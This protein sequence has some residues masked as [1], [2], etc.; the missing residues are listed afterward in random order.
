M[1][2]VQTA[3]QS[4]SNGGSTTLDLSGVPEVDYIKIRWRGQRYKETGSNS[5]SKNT[6]STT[7]TEFHTYNPTP[8][9]P[10]GYN[11]DYHKISSQV[12][13]VSGD[14][15]DL[16][17]KHSAESDYSI[18]EN[19]GY[20]VNTLSMLSNYY[21]TSRDSWIEIRAMCDRY[22]I[23]DYTLA[24]TIY[25]YY[26][27]YLQ[28]EDISASVGG[29]TTTGPAYL[30]NDDVSN[31]YTLNNVT[32]DA[33]NTI[34]HSVSSAEQVEYQ[35]EYSPSVPLAPATTIDSEYDKNFSDFTFTLTENESVPGPYH[36][37]IT[38]EGTTYDTMTSVTDWYYWDGAAWQA[39][40]SAGV[41]PD[42]KVKYEYTN[43]WDFGDYDWSARG[44]AEI[45]SVWTAGDLAEFVLTIRRLSAPTIVSPGR[46][47]RYEGRQPHFV[48]EV[49][50]EEY[51][52]APKHQARLKLSQYLDMDPLLFEFESETA[53]YGTWQYYDG[54]TWTA[55]PEA[56]VDPGTK[57]R[58]QPNSEL[59]YGIYY[60]EIATHNGVDW[61]SE[62]YPA[63]L[64]TVISA[65]VMYTLYIEGTGYS[66]YDL[67][68]S[69]TANGALGTISFS[70]NNEDGTAENTINYGD[71]VTVVVMDSLGNE[72]E[73]EGK[74][75]EKD[76]SL[77]LRV[78]CI[79]GDGILSERRIKE[80][81]A[82]QDIGQTAKDVID[83]YCSPLTSTNIDTSTGYSRAYEST[84]Q[85]P[86]QLLESMRREY[87]IYY[88]VDANWDVHLFTDSDLTN[89]SIVVRRGD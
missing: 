52:A 34:S 4:V 89:G 27:R 36:A 70:L 75:R 8:S 43:S 77:E 22:N 3:W 35:I 16:F 13:T 83:T 76:P 30:S 67:S 47:E 25:T 6:T 50:D 23:L 59:D 42:T 65:D 37:E 72:E 24:T 48:F 1:S 39:F 86:I 31:W 62:T 78:D 88:F 61:S 68:V 32:A 51:Q 54:A 14:T 55:F 20:D 40:P 21:P 9:V 44:Y 73:Y 74:V 71:S 53:A 79:C 45:D 19:E 41:D 26:Y 84:D 38:I 58:V 17:L 87:G 81:Y 2:V 57:I 29:T 60:W 69:E 80:D 15:T 11:F 85:K 28:S 33:S 63:K 49:T 10:G 5:D 66:A 64:F 7:Q 18:E 56:G 46:D 82:S 12:D